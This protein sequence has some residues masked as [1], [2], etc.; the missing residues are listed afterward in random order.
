[1]SEPSRVELSSRK[2]SRRKLITTGLAATAGVSAIGVAARLAQKYGLVPPDH[3]GIYGLGETLTYASQRLLTRHSLAREFSRSQISK[4]PF[5]NEMAPPS[6][7]FKRLQSGGFAGWRLT[8]N[9][10]VSKPSSFSLDQLK[11][12]PSRSQITMIQCEE[13]W[14]YI[15]EWNGVPLSHVLDAVQVHPQARYVVYFSIEP[16]WWESIDMADAM[17]PQTFL[18]YGMNGDELPVGNGGPLRLRVPRQLGYKNVKFLTHLTV[19]DNLKSFG[20]GLGSASP[21]SGYAWYA[22]I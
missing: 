19:T 17:H 18:T 1:M 2:L 13:G 15:A 14:S 3:G 8:V 12:Y 22:G 16:D 4:P 21:E 7:A 5:P 20:K 9:G 6:D 11:S 10:M